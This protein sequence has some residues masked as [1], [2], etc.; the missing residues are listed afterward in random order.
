MKKLIIMCKWILICTILL[1]LIGLLVTCYFDENGCL[2]CS[3]SGKCS[4]CKGKREVIKEN[5]GG[6]KEVV[7][8]LPC[9]KTGT[10]RTCN[11]SGKRFFL[12]Q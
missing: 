1:S 10:C 12:V 5:N 4:Y 3:G 7:P 8:C 2:S 9:V 6:F 11:G